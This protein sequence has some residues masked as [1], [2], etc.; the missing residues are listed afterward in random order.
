VIEDNGTQ[1]D[2]RLRRILAVTDAALS[3]LDTETLLGELLE[4]VR[5]LL[6]ADAAAFLL[7]DA[8]TQQL[9]TVAAIG[10]EDEVTQGIR[11]DVG[12]G[13]AGAVAATK[14][15]II[16]D[17]VDESS[18][19]SP[20]LR[21]KGL[22]T[23]VGVPMFAGGDVLGVLH[24]GTYA[25]RHFTEQDVALLQLVADRAGLA[26]QARQTQADRAA[27]LALQ[28][29]LLPGRLPHPEGIDLAAR[30][31]PGHHLGVGGDW[32]DVF[33]LP[34]G[35]LG[36]VVGDVTGHGL[37]AAVVMGRLRSALR[38]YAI[39]HDDPAEVLTRLDRKITHF[40]AGN[41]ATV[42]YAL[43]TPD[44][45]RLLISSAGHPPP[46]M[47]AAKGAACPLVLPTD[48]LVGTGWRLPRHSTSIDLPKRSTIVFYT[49]GLVERRGEVIDEGIQ[50]LCRAIDPSP[51][52]AVCRTVVARMGVA[53]A[54]DD[55]AILAMHR[56]R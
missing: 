50:R 3:Y 56:E 20:V 1:R 37:R 49:D 46:V 27:T 21:D 17:H 12:S 42:L 28:R 55:I 32:Y 30:Y 40:E 4:R 54:E 8:D 16:V 35:H 41:L 9:A 25:Q 53:A 29:S 13:F 52:E 18:V 43:L 15:P 6:D 33:P 10:L 48:A 31:V 24:V 34:S 39:E 23:L 22:S 19:V 38:S 36:V 11:V 51:A 5:A 2:E 14:A 47:A 45:D 44:R 7:L 26:S